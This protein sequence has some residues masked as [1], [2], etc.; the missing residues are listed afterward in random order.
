MFINHDIKSNFE[1]TIDFNTTDFAGYLNA[2]LHQW[3]R[4]LTMFGYTLVP[5]FFILDYFTVPSSLL[6]KFGLLRLISVFI[7]LVQYFIIRTTRP[8]AYSFLHGYFI[9]LNVGGAISIMTSLLGGFSSG[10]YAGLNLVMV[11]VNMLLPWRPI[12]S[13]INSVI[14]ISM[15]GFINIFFSPPADLV[16]MTN[17]L[18]FMFGTAVISIG[19]NYVKNKLEEKEFFLRSELKKT[20]DA[21]WGEMEIAKRIQTALLPHKDSISCHTDKKI[22]CYSIASTMIPAD[23][24][25]GDYYD[26]IETKS[27]ER[28][29]AIGDVT[30]HGVE[31]GLIMMMTQTSIYSIVNNTSGYNPSS[32]LYAINS[33]IRENISR[34]GAD[35][36]VAVS[37]LRLND[38]RLVVAGK[39]QDLL[40]YRAASQTVETVTIAGTWI[41]I[42]DNIKNHMPDVTVP[43]DI[44][45]ILLL[46]TDGITEATNR[47]GMMYGQERL[48]EVF[49]S[50]IALPVNELLKNI[51]ID[52]SGFWERQYDDVT[53]VVVRRDH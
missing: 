35:R 34:L 17:H 33:V 42:Y 30:G 36:Y 7:I 23:E 9:S 38:T 8:G 4:T 6:Y 44:G 50:N 40:I 15:Y 53:A 19:I 18:F 51:I 29:L 47:S 46:F 25:G 32:I 1:E 21:L 12:H 26:I 39:H 2:L 43:I 24:I 3:L 27:G 11:A 10:Y 28:W 16:V 52:V 13:A 49:K 20:R 31:S 37:L 41:G 45:D 48:A 5:F 14:I 22:G